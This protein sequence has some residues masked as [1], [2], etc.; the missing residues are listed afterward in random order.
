LTDIEGHTVVDDTVVS[1]AVEEID[2]LQR[3]YRGFQMIL[4]PLVQEQATASLSEITAIV[5]LYLG[6][7]GER[8]A[9]P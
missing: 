8:S 1:L 2:T 9:S 4:Y 7:E 3:E 6:I 5:V